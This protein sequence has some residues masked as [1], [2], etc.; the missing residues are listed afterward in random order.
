M[1]RATTTLVVARTR[2]LDPPRTPDSAG[3]GLR[4]RVNQRGF[5]AEGGAWSPAGVVLFGA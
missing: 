2:N 3:G 4:H 1:P 5:A